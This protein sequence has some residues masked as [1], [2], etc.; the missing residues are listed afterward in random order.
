MSFTR[1]YNKTTLVKD[2]PLD[3]YE[4]MADHFYLRYYGWF[5]EPIEDFPRTGHDA[6]VALISVCTMAAQI[7]GLLYPCNWFDSPEDNR[8]AEFA[9]L[10]ERWFGDSFPVFVIPEPSDALTETGLAAR[11]Y[12]S[13][14][15]G[16]GSDSSV[17]ISG[18]G[19]LY[20]RSDD[21]VDIIDPWIL[22]DRVKERFEEWCRTAKK[23]GGEEG[24]E[25]YMR[26]FRAAAGLD[27]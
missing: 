18:T 27:S 2:L 25:P 10:L 6:F 5:L 16:S 9:M 11:F 7:G 24:R 8:T 3:D 17:G 14:F 26:V 1:F 22:R 13:V 15:N 21:G 19:V 12:K 4:A 23:A 20:T